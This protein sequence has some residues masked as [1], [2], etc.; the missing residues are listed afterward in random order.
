MKW[1]EFFKVKLYPIAATT[2]MKRFQVHFPNEN[3]FLYIQT[4]NFIYFEMTAVQNTVFLQRTLQINNL[5]YFHVDRVLSIISIYQFHWLRSTIFL[6][7]S[8]ICSAKQLI[9]RMQKKKKRKRIIVPSRK[10]FIKCE[11]E[12][13]ERV[14]M[15][16]DLVIHALSQTQHTHTSFPTLDIRLY[17]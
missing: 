3:S 5:E 15:T 17:I 13:F 7:C 12:R 6:F 16:K 11:R 10:L 2:F 8:N 1:F 9:L 4:I 14:Y